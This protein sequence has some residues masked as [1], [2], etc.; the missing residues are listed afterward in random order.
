[1]EEKDCFSL[2]AFLYNLKRSTYAKMDKKIKNIE[3][4]GEN[5]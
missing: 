2:F 3:M 5:I 4:E 1:M